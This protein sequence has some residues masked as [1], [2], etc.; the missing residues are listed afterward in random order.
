MTFGRTEKGRP[1][2]SFRKNGSNATHAATERAKA[3][4]RTAE[5]RIP[6]VSEV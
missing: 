5:R 3:A 1:Q 2:A 4:L 6:G